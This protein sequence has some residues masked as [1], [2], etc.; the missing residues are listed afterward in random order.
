MWPLHI[1]MGIFAHTVLLP[2]YMQLLCDLSGLGDPFS[3]KENAINIRPVSQTGDL[4]WGFLTCNPGVFSITSLQIMERPMQNRLQFF[5]NS[6]IVLTQTHYFSNLFYCTNLSS[7]W[8]CSWR[9]Q[10]HMATDSRAASNVLKVLISY[11]Q[12]DYE[13]PRYVVWCYCWQEKGSLT[14]STL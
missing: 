7:Q 8:Q 11:L 3:V 4:W 14:L 10:K 6:R 13:N 9:K 12:S 2:V 5:Q 1:T